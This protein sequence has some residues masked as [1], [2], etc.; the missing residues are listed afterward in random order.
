[1]SSLKELAGMRFGRW[2]VLS[3]SPRPE[4][5][6]GKDAW[7]LCRCDCGTESIVNGKNLRTGQTLSCGCYRSETTSKRLKGQSRKGYGNDHYKTAAEEA[8]T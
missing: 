2:K 6:T 5:H 8:G 7:W 1:M 3:R 4:Y